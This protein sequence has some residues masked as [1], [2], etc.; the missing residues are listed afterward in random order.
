MKPKKFNDSKHLMHELVASSPR[1]SLNHFSHPHSI[2]KSLVDSYINS[3][4][5]P[6]L[7]TIS[8]KKSNVLPPLNCF[9]Y[10]IS[11]NT[12]ALTLKSQLANFPTKTN[13]KLQ[14]ALSHEMIATKAL[15]PTNDLHILLHLDHLSTASALKW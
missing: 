6:N 2:V 10:G 4:T 12:S 8:G 9:A 5:S 13:S 14:S 15:N 3:S 11:P 7:I 1:S